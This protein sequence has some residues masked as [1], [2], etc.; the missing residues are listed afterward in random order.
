VKAVIDRVLR[1]LKRSLN[2]FW[3]QVIGLS[4]E[5]KVLLNN[6]D[7]KITTR[8]RA[9]DDDQRYQLPVGTW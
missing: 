5:A 6:T 2:V 8:S 3:R 7:S 1:N 9:Y 4:L